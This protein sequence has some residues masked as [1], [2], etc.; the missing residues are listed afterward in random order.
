MYLFNCN[1]NNN[2]NNFQIYDHKK[3]IKN[4]YKNLYFIS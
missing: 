1:D 3:I 4:D 2:N